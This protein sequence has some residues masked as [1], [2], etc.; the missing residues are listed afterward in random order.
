V[1][2]KHQCQSFKSGIEFGIKVDEAG[3]Q[4]HTAA[5]AAMR[6]QYESLVKSGQTV[7]EQFRIQGMEANRLRGLLANLTDDYRAARSARRPIRR[8]RPA[9]G[10]AA[11]S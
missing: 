9:G 7:H 11:Q 4:K 5:T 1:G 3:L 8:N 6:Q 2:G 10:G